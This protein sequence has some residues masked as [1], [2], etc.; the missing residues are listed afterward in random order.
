[1]KR[2]SYY[3]LLAV[4]LLLSLTLVPAVPAAAQEAPPMETAW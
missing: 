4:M 3:I 1:M 2:V